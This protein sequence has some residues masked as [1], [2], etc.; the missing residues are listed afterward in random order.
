MATKILPMLALVGPL[1]ACSTAAQQQAVAIQT[2]LQ[3]A[4][5]Q[6]KSCEQQVNNRPEYAALRPHI[7]EGNPTAADLADTSLPTAAE[8]ELL[9]RYTVDRATCDNAARSQIVATDPAVAQALDQYIFDFNSIYADLITRRITWADAARREQ[10]IKSKDGPAIR[11]AHEATMHT[12]AAQHR[13]EVAERQAR[14]ADVQA[15]LRAIGG[16]LLDYANATRNIPSVSVA[17]AA[18]PTYC[19]GHVD[20]NGNVQATCS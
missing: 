20:R 16:V 1:M 13:Q 5:S 6:A 14:I 11:E 4:I 17:P 18:G 19:N 7:H 10:E 9:K 8:A 12:L 3:A 15:R 2:G